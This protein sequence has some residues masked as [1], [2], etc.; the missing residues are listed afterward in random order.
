ME[1]WIVVLNYNLSSFA[2]RHFEL[3]SALPDVGVVAVDNASAPADVKAL[4]TRAEQLGG[5]V[6]AADARTDVDAGVRRA[7]EAG[8]RLIV[9]CSEIN[10]GFSSGNNLALRA[11]H[12][13]LGARGRYLVT[14]PD[15]ELTAD[16]VRALFATP[17]DIVG[18]A[19]WEGYLDGLR[20]YED[21]C[22]FAT[23]FVEEG[24]GSRHGVLGVRLCGCCMRF[25]GD[26]LARY[27]F[28]PDKNF[29]YDEETWYFETVHRLGGRPVYV[30]QVTVR[31]AGSAAEGKKGFNYFYYI[32]RNRLVYFLEVARPRY[33][34]TALFVLRYGDWALH[35]LLNQIK[36]R[37]W[38]GAKGVVVGIWHGLKR[39]SGRFV[40]RSSQTA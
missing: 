1:H 17:G 32:F 16:A 34:R 26:A 3:L 28:L 27:G 35:V 38:D 19:I 29:L 25:T 2:I 15:V 21:R 14:N 11:L 24:T 20:P 8:V 9:L 37:N 13:I 18:P 40:A 12:R 22:D 33:G 4:V 6:L 39:R 7:L 23:G 5:L 10:S 30:P 36:K 31:H